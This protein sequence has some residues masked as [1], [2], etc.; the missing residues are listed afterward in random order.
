MKAGGDVRLM[1][2]NDSGITLVEL[3][4]TITILG[5][6]L[7]IG[8]P[9]MMKAI[10]RSETIAKEVNSKLLLSIIQTYNN[11]QL[12]KNR[13]IR[14]VTIMC[15]ADIPIDEVCLRIPDD[16]DWDMLYPIFIDS[17]GKGSIEYEK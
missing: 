9:N 13:Q 2:I 3:I 11:E 16:F 15:K 6:L 1:I 8:V 10:E 17:D 14:D 7:S 5:I 4:V 12:N